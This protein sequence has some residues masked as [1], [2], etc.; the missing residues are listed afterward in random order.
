[1]IFNDKKYGV[2]INDLYGAINN[3]PN[4]PLNLTKAEGQV[5]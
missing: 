2:N 5:K 4:K 1:M 3:P